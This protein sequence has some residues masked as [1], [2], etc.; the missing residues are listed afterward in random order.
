MHPVRVAYAEPGGQIGAVGRAVDDR[1][2]DRRVVEYRG[3]I[4]DDL[5]D[6]QRLGRKVRTSIVVP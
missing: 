5:V 6:G 3:H 4:V 1:L 2:V